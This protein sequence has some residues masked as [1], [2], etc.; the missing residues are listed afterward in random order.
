MSRNTEVVEAIAQ[1]RTSCLIAAMC[2][3]GEVLLRQALLADKGS[4]WGRDE[5][6]LVN[7]YALCVLLVFNTTSA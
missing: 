5:Q 7:Q 1:A 6:V 4:Q 3:D 2:T